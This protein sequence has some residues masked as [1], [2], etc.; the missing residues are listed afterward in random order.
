VQIARSLD[1]TTV[2]EGIEDRATWDTLV[3]LGCDNMQGYVLS[4]ALASAA[5][6]TLLNQHDTSLWR[7][8]PTLARQSKPA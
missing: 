2:A 4:P 8:R 7:V 5:F 3:D 6:L 1:L